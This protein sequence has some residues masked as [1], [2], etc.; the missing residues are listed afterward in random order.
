ML[1]V[2]NLNK[3]YK[4]QVVIHDLSFAIGPG[5][6][7]C[8][9][10]PSGAGKTTLI[11][12]LSG[13]D[14]AFT[15]MVETTA[16]RRCTVFQDPGLFWYKTVAENIRYPLSLTRMPF[17]GEIRERYREWLAVTGLSAAEHRYPYQISGG[18]K[19]KTALVRA[20]LPHPDLVLLDEAFSWMDLESKQA[21]MAHIQS[22]YP[23]TTLLMATHGLDEISAM[24]QTVWAF[25]ERRLS[26]YQNI[27]ISSA[28]GF[29]DLARTLFSGVLS[30]KGC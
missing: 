19:Q 23:E 28:T 12:I 30:A 4:N 14:E 8:I 3:H 18:M 21:I 25:R 9:F 5:A 7:V 13:L 1:K 27:P 24:A 6:R 29:E 22:R 11:H 2:R 16:R 17:E 10:A 15:G 20:F 26:R